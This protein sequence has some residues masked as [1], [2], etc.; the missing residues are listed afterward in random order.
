MIKRALD[1]L[2]RVTNM[3]EST[4]GDNF[5]NW[6]QLVETPSFFFSNQGSYSRDEGYLDNG[7]THKYNK[8]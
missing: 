4:E 2:Q 3:A 1:R 5:D 6:Y 8:W 7:D